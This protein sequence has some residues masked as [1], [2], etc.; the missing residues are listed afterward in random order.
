M[1][2]VVELRSTRG[3]QIASSEKL[4]KLKSIAGP[5][6]NRRLSGDVDARFPL[7]PPL[8]LDVEKL[9][10]VIS[11]VLTFWHIKFINVGLLMAFV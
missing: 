10:V 4:S 5:P 11:D 9:F 1:A 6:N 7:A 2:A 8:E 3:Q